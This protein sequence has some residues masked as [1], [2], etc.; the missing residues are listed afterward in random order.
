MSATAAPP[1]AGGY[2]VG[3]WQEDCSQPYPCLLDS[4]W[5]GWAQ[6][7]FGAET[8]RRVVLDQ[9]KLVASSGAE[10]LD[11][12]TFS[13]GGKPKIIYADGGDME[14]IEPVQIGGVDYY[15]FGLGWC[16]RD[17][18]ENGQAVERGTEAISET[19]RRLARQ[20]VETDKPLDMV[21]GLRR[22]SPNGGFLFPVYPRSGSERRVVGEIEIRPDGSFDFFEIEDGP[23]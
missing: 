19:Y 6:P 21:G 11:R 20:Y 23:R 16:W 5:N 7:L 17:V 13:E 18:D 15:P 2:V 4:Y 12:L 10:E 8:V 9:E 14:Y 22:P 3:D 1:L